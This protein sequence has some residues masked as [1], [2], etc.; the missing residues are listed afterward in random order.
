ML[1]LS[2]KLSECIEIGEDIRVTVMQ[3]KP[4]VVRIGIDAP[5]HVIIRRTELPPKSGTESCTIAGLRTVD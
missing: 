5:K 1:V 3:I 2:R 4:G